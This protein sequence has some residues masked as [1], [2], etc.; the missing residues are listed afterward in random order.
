MWRRRGRARPAESDWDRP[1]CLVTRRTRERPG[2]RR[3]RRPRV[4]PVRPRPRGRCPR[5]RR[6]AR[7][8]PDRPTRALGRRRA[9]EARFARGGGGPRCHVPP[10]AGASVGPESAEDGVRWSA[11]RLGAV[12]LR[13]GTHLGCLDRGRECGFPIRHLVRHRGVR[14]LRRRH[15]RR[16]R[17]GLDASD[18]TG[19][20]AEVSDSSDGDTSDGDTSDGTGAP[21]EASTAEVSDTSDADTSDAGTSDA[22][23]DSRTSDGATSAAGR[24]SA[25]GEA[26]G[27]GC[28]RAG[29]PGGAQSWNPAGRGTAS[30]RAGAAAATAGPAGAAQAL[31]CARASAGAPPRAGRPE[32]MR[33]TSALPAASRRTKRRV[34]PGRS[35][36]AVD[37]TTTP[38]PRRSERP[39]AS[40][41]SKRSCAPD[42]LGC[43]RGEEESVTAHVGAVLVDELVLA[44]EGQPDAEWRRRGHGRGSKMPRIRSLPKSSGAKPHHTR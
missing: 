19:A 2:E 29:A 26:A 14:H 35:P 6:P 43:A 38:S 25:S 5:G 15:L 33:S 13:G 24:A 36:E 8:R 44:A 3:A 4:L 41:R 22:T 11:H 18:G 37:R 7:R 12:R 16:S 40:T 34:I 42:R 27:S 31:G 10:S 32:T 20:A 23:E 17:R 39:S 30:R 9:E 1:R 28:G 21:A